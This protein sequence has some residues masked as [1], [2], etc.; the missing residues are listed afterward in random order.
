MNPLKYHWVVGGRDSVFLPLGF[1]FKEK[2]KK[3]NEN[4]FYGFKCSLDVADIS[5][6]IINVEH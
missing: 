5:I 3:I 2:L 1:V 4:I 6:K